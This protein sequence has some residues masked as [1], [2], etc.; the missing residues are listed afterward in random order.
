MLKR[1]IET[2]VSDVSGLIA[3]SGTAL[4]VRMLGW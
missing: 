1:N 2:S 4:R 3:R